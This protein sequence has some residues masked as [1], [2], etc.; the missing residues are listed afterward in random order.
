MQDLR[1]SIIKHSLIDP[2][3]N[4]KA[5]PS[6]DRERSVLSFDSYSFLHT[7]IKVSRI[8][9]T[10]GE[11]F[12]WIFIYALQRTLFLTLHSILKFLS[13]NEN[14]SFFQV[15]VL[16][17]S[18]FDFLFLEFVKS[19]SSPPKQVYKS[20]IFAESFQILNFLSLLGFFEFLE[21]KEVTP[22]EKV[23][24]TLPIEHKN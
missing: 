20:L 21:I 12:L 16:L 3:M 10:I 24:W 2:R 7:V 23:K 4:S 17:M 11:H 18:L 14:R 5:Y 1:N 19:N 6:R 15:H 13:I 22:N 8:A 9:W